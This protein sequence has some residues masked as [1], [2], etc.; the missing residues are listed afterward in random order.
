MHWWST[1][2]TTDAQGRMEQLEQ[3]GSYISNETFPITI[4][5]RDDKKLVNENAEC[6]YFSSL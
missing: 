1:S 5:L 2:N 3:D 6:R 4:K